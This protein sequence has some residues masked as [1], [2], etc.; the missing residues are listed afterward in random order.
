MTQTVSLAGFENS[1]KLALETESSWTVSRV[2]EDDDYVANH[3]PFIE[4]ETLES[5]D[6]RPKV[7]RMCV[8]YIVY[9]KQNQSY[10][11]MLFRIPLFVTLTCLILATLTSNMFRFGFISIGFLVLCESMISLTNFA[12][13]FYKSTF[14]KFVPLL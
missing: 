4:F 8:T 11:R 13:T 12:P 2:S 7:Q 9:L 6:E 14:G 10:F 5:L 1:I 3:L